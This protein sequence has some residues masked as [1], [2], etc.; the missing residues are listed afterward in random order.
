MK[1]IKS[2]KKALLILSS[3]LFVFSAQSQE[4]Q[5]L[6]D[7]ALTNSPEI[8]KIDFQYQIA[9]EKVNEVNSLPNTEFN[10]GFMAVKPEM[11]MPM[12]RFRVSVM[13]MLP[14]FGT[15]TARENYATSMADAQ[16]V[17]V[18]IAKRKLALSV[19]QFY[20]QLYEIRTKQEVLDKNIA[21]LESYERLALTS[22]EVGKASAVDVLR[23]QI[24]Q[25]ELIQEK[26]VLTQQNKG[27]QA[28]LNS[29]MNRDY[30]QEV[31][32]V[33]TMDIPEDDAF[34][35]YDALTLNPELLKYD[36]LY[37]SIEQ[38]ELLNQKEGG[39]M[40]GFGVE[41]INQEKSPMITSSY[42]DMI[43]PMVSVSI[44]IFNKKYKSQTKQNDLR[45]QE[46]QFQK[47]ER[48]NALK[49]EL[50]K[51]ISQRNQSR[52]TF[53]TQKNN[54]KQ[55]E[56]AEEILIKNYETGTIDFKDVLDVQELQ[57][58]FQMGQIESIKAYFVQT[59]I[60]NYLTQQT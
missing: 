3:F 17:E 14:W 11:D 18:T 16:Y 57:L 58:K 46:L 55:A 54:L 33:T 50:S 40:I 60:I 6:I 4:L 38:S 31:T 45:K 26:D 44:P 28:A 48:M 53:N 13:Q 32:I 23:L 19:S 25:N 9:S 43:M 47:D 36:K 1:P 20:Y 56:N 27:I 7:E 10:A 29:L 21:L 41:Y 51:A 22:L 2:S 35:G 42:K 12:E 39:P 59:S 37:E 30:N 8:Q 49:S 5:T 52:I 34:N 15:I 24:R